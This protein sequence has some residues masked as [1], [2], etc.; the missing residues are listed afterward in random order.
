MSALWF[1][2]EQ[3]FSLLFV[4][5]KAK[6]CPREPETIQKSARKYPAVPIFVGKSVPK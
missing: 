2:V 4:R 5:A 6:S 1:K 3:A